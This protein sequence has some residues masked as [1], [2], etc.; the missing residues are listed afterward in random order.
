MSRD[1]A[2]FFSRGGENRASEDSF[3]LPAGSEE[4]GIETAPITG[5]SPE[6]TKRLRG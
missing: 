2:S 6:E 3:V 4:Q 1:I 5:A